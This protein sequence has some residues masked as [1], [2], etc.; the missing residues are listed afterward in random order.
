MMA[1]Q[2]HHEQQPWCQR[3]PRRAMLRLRTHLSSPLASDCVTGQ[4]TLTLTLCQKTRLSRPDAPRHLL[5]QLQ[6]HPLQ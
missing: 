4:P 2:P 3:L 5:Q 1:H 6:H